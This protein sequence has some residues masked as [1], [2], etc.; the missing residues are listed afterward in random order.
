MKGIMI[1]YPDVE[2]IMKK[3]AVFAELQKKTEEKITNSTAQSEKQRL[4]NYILM[5]L[6]KNDVS[7]KISA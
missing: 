1:L 4:K 6:L 3:N 2:I 5:K 7:T